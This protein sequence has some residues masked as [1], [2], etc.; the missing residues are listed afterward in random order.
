MAVGA[1]LCEESRVV[2]RLRERTDH[3]MDLHTYVAALRKLWWAIVLATLIGAGAG[4]Y[5]AYRQTP[6]YAS[7]VTFFAT[8]ETASAASGSSAFAG[9]QFA[10]QRVN[11]YVFLLSSDRLASMVIADSKVDL[12]VTDVQ[13][14]IT[15]SSQLN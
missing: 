13:S 8:T 5:L 7:T 11:T 14:K 10:Q 3:C 12:S 2:A 15:G 1:I 4:G 9:D 6:Q